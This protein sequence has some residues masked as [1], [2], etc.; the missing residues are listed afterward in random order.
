MFEIVIILALLMGNG[1]FAMA[2][3]ALVSAKK[4]RLKSMADA[5]NRGAAEALELLSEPSQFLSTVQIG[6]T[7]V[8]IVAG[9][10]G[11]Q[12]LTP[13]LAPWIEP[14]PILGAWSTTIAYGSVIAFLTYLS[15]VI[16]ELIPKR[17]AMM[18]PEGISA[19][20]AAPMATLSFLAK[21]AVWFL[22]KSTDL[23]L[24]IFG[25]RPNPEDSGVTRD[26]VTVLVREATIAG[27]IQRAE[28]ELVE[29]VFELSELGVS[30]LMTPRPKIVWLRADDA[31]DKI[32][33]KIVVSAHSHFPVYESN[34]DQVI[35]VVSVK[36]MYAQ[37]AAGIP[38]RLRDVAM[39]PLIVP[40]TQSA[41]K[42][43]HT[44]KTTGTHVALVVDEFGSVV[45]L[46]TLIDLMEA[47][48]GDMPSRNERL[49]AVIKPRSDGTWLVDAMV[50]IE[51]LTE[52][53][54]GLKLPEG[55]YQTLAGFIIDR[56]ECIPEE[57]DELVHEGY[58]FEVLDMDGRRID[59]VLI[60][61]IKKSDGKFEVK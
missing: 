29:G 57:G 51:K 24:R 17:F 53:L 35:G 9:S 32:W 16:G 6:I 60:A 59:K 40:E 44:F 48:V 39:P 33:H 61:G 3:I 20:M 5:G 54:P 37:L 13:L 34:R 25:M 1:L 15:L 45:G 42:L 11:G 49:Q 47:I 36:S 21:P 30:D 4:A 8:G 19:R 18:W 12:S 2:E 41:L 23:G 52:E 27:S 22:T 50:D 28:S 56:L 38:V 7:L 58:R 46:V 43:L 10:Y 14:L 26:E 55:D 31:H